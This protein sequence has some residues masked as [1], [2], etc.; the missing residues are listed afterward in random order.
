MGAP[1]SAQAAGARPYRAGGSSRF[2]TILCVAAFAF[3]ARTGLGITVRID[4]LRSV[5]AAALRGGNS[6]A[7][8]DYLGLAHDLRDAQFL[9]GMGTVAFAGL[10]FV[11]GVRAV[12]RRRTRNGNAGLGTR[13]E[14]ELASA[15][16]WPTQARAIAADV[17]VPIVRRCR[18]AALSASTTANRG[19]SHARCRPS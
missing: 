3:M 5:A 7:Y 9:F 18:R 2:S 1:T 10:L 8:Y 6:D 19:P 12:I 13:C 14:G 17:L 4:Y 16:L 11:L 15:R